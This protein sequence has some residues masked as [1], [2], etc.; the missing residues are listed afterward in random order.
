ISIAIATPC[1]SC[2]QALSLIIQ[3]FYFSGSFFYYHFEANW[4]SFI[5]AY[6]FRLEF[7]ADRALKA[8]KKPC[9][10][11]RERPIREKFVLKVFGKGYGVDSPQCGEM[12]RSDKGERLGQ[13]NLSSERFPPIIS[14]KVSI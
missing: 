11:C 13:R 4:L 7:F 5:L 3:D 2:T 6:I 8:I 14:C 10:F 1:S 9:K 12:S